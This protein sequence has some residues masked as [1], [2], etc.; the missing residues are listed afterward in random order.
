MLLGE[1]NMHVNNIAISDFIR[2]IQGK[3]LVAFGASVFLKVIAMNYEELDLARNI[4]YIVDNDFAKDGH[5][6]DL[7]GKQIEIH[8]LD[9]LLKDCSDD[10]VLLIAS[11]RFA[12]EIYE[13]LSNIPELEEVKCLCLSTIIAN[14]IEEEVQPYW[15]KTGEKIQKII[16]CFWFSGSPKDDMAKKCIE[17]WRKYCPDFE[18]KEWTSENYDVSK[19]SYMYDAYKAK[20]WAYATDY[21]RLDVIYEYGGFYFDLDLEIIRDIRELCSADFIAGFGPLRD[22]ELAAFGAM[23]HSP[24]VG[25]MLDKYT[26]RTFNPLHLPLTEVQPIFMD[27]FMKQH[28]FLINGQFQNKDNQILFDRY[29]FS[30]RNWFTGEH[31]DTSKSYGIHHCAGSWIEKGEK[32]ENRNC[33]MQQLMKIFG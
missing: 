19:N 18:I 25:E 10:I 26:N 22:I 16:H 23:K 29:A 20:K 5:I 11:E 6:Y 27:N 12:Y 24:L 14:H 33:N 4:A 7:C 8:S 2:Y 15:Q 13:Q 3:K 21:A 32:N 9:F 28:G 1:L 31:L 30:P 17:S